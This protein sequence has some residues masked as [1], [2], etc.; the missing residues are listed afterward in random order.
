MSKQGVVRRALVAMLAVFAVAS[1][2]GCRDALRDGITSGIEDGV[3][4]LVVTAL[5]RIFE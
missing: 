1:I 4:G 5:E 3:N 2:S